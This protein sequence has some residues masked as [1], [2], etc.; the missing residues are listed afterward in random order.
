MNAVTAVD[1][2]RSG[3]LALTFAIAFIVL[4][5]A[6]PFLPYRFGPYPLVNWADVVDLATPLVL[7]PVYWLLLAD[8]RAA[9]TT[10]WVVLFLVLAAAWVEGHGIHLIANATGHLLNGQSGRAV[11]LNEFADEV[12]SHY[13]WHG[14]ALALSA[15]I[16]F[17]AAGDDQAKGP[18]WMGATA[19]LIY[20]FAVF[21]VGDEGG[22]P[23]LVVPFCAAVGVAAWTMRRRLLSSPILTLFGLGYPFALVLFAIWFAIWHGTLPQFSHLGWIK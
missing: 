18:V 4:F 3:V 9:L 2:R 1:S 10:R 6:P 19:A 14:A 15:L 20:G 16:L 5:L 17:R 7:I 21:L 23:P 12:F 11:D 8:G 22:T 13:V